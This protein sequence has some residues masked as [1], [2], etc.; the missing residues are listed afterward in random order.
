MLSDKTPAQIL[1]GSQAQSR[2]MGNCISPGYVWT[3]LVGKQIPK[4][5]EGTQHERGS[6]D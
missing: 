6:G 1:C 4:N 3:P 5:D 2:I